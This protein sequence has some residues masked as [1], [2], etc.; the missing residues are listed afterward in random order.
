MK[1]DDV[2]YSGCLQKQTQ[3]MLKHIL[4]QEDMLNRG[5]SAKNWWQIFQLQL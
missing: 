2:Y 4:K 5:S 1:T 3:D